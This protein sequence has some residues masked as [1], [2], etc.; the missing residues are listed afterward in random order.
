MLVQ[1]CVEL[2]ESLVFEPWTSDDK[3]ASVSAASVLGPAASVVLL[4][5][6]LLLWMRRVRVR[7]SSS[8]RERQQ[9]GRGLVA[10][11]L[12]RRRVLLRRLVLRLQEMLRRRPRGRRRRCGRVARLRLRRP[13]LRSRPAERRRVRMLLH[14]WLVYRLLWLLWLLRRRWLRPGFH[15]RAAPPQELLLPHH[16]FPRRLRG[17]AEPLLHLLVPLA[18]H[19]LLCV[20]LLRRP[21]PA[22]LVLLPL[23]QRLQRL[24]G[25]HPAPKLTQHRPQPLLARLS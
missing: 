22:L 25:A 6:P 5:R 18:L 21:V 3:A 11:V 24:S 9:A 16:H 19:L 2:T 15:P 13:L 20:P 14:R 8:L 1:Q 17:P 23:P 7:S 12:W 10:A 4:R